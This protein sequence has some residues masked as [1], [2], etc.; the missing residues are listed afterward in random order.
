MSQDATAPLCIQ[1]V[2]RKA[3]LTRL[4]FNPLHPV[5]MVGDDRWA[6]DSM[7]TEEPK[8]GLWYSSPT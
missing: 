3:H 2:V 5:L 8:L 7:G 1:K 4:A 6:D